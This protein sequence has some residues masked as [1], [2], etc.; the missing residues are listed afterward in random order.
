MIKI[1]IRAYKH[2]FSFTIPIK[3]IKKI[4]AKTNDY[5][6]VILNNGTKSIVFYSKVPS[7]CPSRTNLQ[8]RRSFP[9]NFVKEFNL[10]RDNFIDLQVSLVKKKRTTKLIYKDKLD[11]LAVIPEKTKTEKQIMVDI[12]K[13]GCEEWCKI[14]YCSG[15]GG[16]V[17]EIKLKRF[18]KIDKNLGE[19]FGLMQ[20]ESSKKSIC[21]DF[22]NKFLSEI[23]LFLNVA[24]KFGIPKNLW[25]YTIFYNPSM[26]S[27]ILN[28]YITYLK[29]EININKVKTCKNKNLLDVIYSIRISHRL[30]AIIMINMLIKLREWA[31]QLNKNSKIRFKEFVKGFILKDLVGD[32][33]VVLNK[34]SKGL[35]IVI[36]EQDRDSQMAIIKIL[37]LF[38]IHSLA[39][40]IKIDVS[41]DFNSC[42]WFLENK[43]F[44]EHKE[45]R[46]K[47][48]I[49]IVNNYYF[50]CLYEK[51]KNLDGCSIKG[52]AE[53][54]NLG[55][56]A[57]QRYIY[58]NIKRGFICKEGEKIYKTTEK[59]KKFVKLMKNAKIDLNKLT[60][61]YCYRNQSSNFISYS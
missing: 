38:D 49:Y 4:G 59:G 11:I 60:L 55:Y 61:H 5:I 58:Q 27:K 50:N 40:G 26:K 29:K 39:H 20:A 31:L 13:K 12:F 22:T 32:G 35:D 54:H 44:I 57:A 8:V 47:L 36:S 34:D 6:K 28:N 43:A 17:K 16:K 24:Q 15:Q 42:L 25:G 46:K 51:I 19:F 30:L 14:W 2:K 21:F 56:K 23:K 10:K 53:K 52:F 7:I 37:N 33:S 41:T 18:I 48:L 45:N 3:I 1:K 9:K